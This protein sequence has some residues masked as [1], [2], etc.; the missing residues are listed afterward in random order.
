[1]KISVRKGLDINLKGEADKILADSN[2]PKLIALK[3]TDFSGLVPKMLVKEG[4]LV[5]CGSPVFCDKYNDQ[6]NYVSHVSGKINEI[7]RGEKRRI[8]AVTIEPDGKMDQ[9]NLNPKDLA[10]S[11][12]EEIKSELMSAGLWP[13]FRMRPIDIVALPNDSPKSIFISG[14][15][16]HPLAPDYDFIMRGKSAEFNAGLEIVSKLTNGD[17]NLQLRSNADEVFTEASNVVINEVSGPHPAG[18]VGVQIHEIDTLNKG[19]VVWYINP[20]DVLVIGRYALTGAYDVSKI[21]AVGGSNISDRKYFKT[22]SGASINSIINDKAI[23]DNSRIISGNVLTG[24]QVDVDGFLGFYHHQLSVIP[25]GNR[26]KF[27]LTDGWLSPGFN[28]FSASR[29]YPS[30]LMPK[31]KSYNLDT[32][33]N[34]EER[35]FVVSGQYEKVFPFDI[36]PVQLLKSIITNDIEKMENLGI[37]EVSPEDFALCEFVC[38]SKVNLQKIV[39]EGLDLIYKEC[40]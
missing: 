31:S 38:T 27:F 7:I 35:A 25:E 18:N 32:N 22:I 37:Y 28:S 36:Y 4:D 16:S 21:I 5:K 15:D 30:W 9:L 20:Q 26:H 17:V 33:L 14:F 19:E 6:I 11:S 10:K 29:A 39:R 1:M 13:F 8:L 23:D 12:S 2:H 3:P 40:M 24:D 34:G